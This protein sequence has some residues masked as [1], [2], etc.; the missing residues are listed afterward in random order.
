M[1]PGAL[2]MFCVVILPDFYTRAAHIPELR[3]TNLTSGVASFIRRGKYGHLL[4]ITTDDKQV[5]IFTCRVGATSGH[6][7]FDSR[8]ND[9]YKG[10]RTDVRWAWMHIGPL[11]THK[12]AIQIVIDGNVVLTRDQAVRRLEI[13]KSGFWVMTAIA[14]LLLAAVGWF[15]LWIRRR[16]EHINSPSH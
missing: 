1:L 14:L 12:H 11:E 15:D 2:Y 16:R 7:C 8:H 13:A 6:E 5:H 3:D 4:K 9:K 10:H